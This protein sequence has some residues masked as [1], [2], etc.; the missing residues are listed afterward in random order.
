MPRQ[1]VDVRNLD[2]A[3]QTALK[4]VNFNKTSIA[5]TASE[6]VTLSSSGGDG[7]KAFAVLVDLNT[8]RH[9]VHYGSWGGANMFTPNNPVDN[10]HNSYPLPG[11]GVAITGS[12][13]G[14]MPVMASLHVPASMVDHILPAS[15]E[16]LPDVELAALAIFQSY[17]SAARPEYLQRHRVT[18]GVLDALVERGLLKRNKAGA[19]SITTDG[20]NA[21]GD[22]T[23]P[24]RY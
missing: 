12:M 13:G 8:N 24:Y 7:S 9:V 1:Y 15:A 16:T 23:L 6:R 2:D 18:S 11:N 19:T 3:I 21:I 4:A 22:Y 10:D 17:K 5:V 20:R 14:G